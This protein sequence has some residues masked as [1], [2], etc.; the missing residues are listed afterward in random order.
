MVDI[1]G[2]LSICNEPHKPQPIKGYDNVAE[3]ARI[4]R[5]CPRM[6]SNI[7]S[8]KRKT[9]WPMR[10]IIPRVVVSDAIGRIGR[11]EVYVVV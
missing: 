8:L 7:D 5:E 6:R 10:E 1:L 9:F 2:H 11:L 4:Y 3:F